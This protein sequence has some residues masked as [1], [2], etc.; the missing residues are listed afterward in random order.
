MDHYARLWPDRERAKRRPN[1][2]HRPLIYGRH[3]LDRDGAISVHQ[4]G[5]VGRQPPRAWPTDESDDHLHHT[6]EVPVVVLPLARTHGCEDDDAEPSQARWPGEA[7]AMAGTT[8]DTCMYERRPSMRSLIVVDVGSTL[9]QFT[10]DG[11]NTTAVLAGLAP[12][13]F[14]RELIARTVCRVLHRTAELTEDVIHEVCDELHID[15]ATWPDPWPA[16]SFRPYEDTLDCLARLNALAPVVALSN[17][18]VTGAPR[19]E[20]LAG[21]CGKYLTRIYPSYQLGAC[22]PARWVWRY[23]ADQHDVR[24]HHVI[25]IGDRWGEDVLGPLGV[26]GRAVW[27]NAAGMPLPDDSFVATGRCAVV[28]SLS[29]A[30][31][32][33]ERWIELPVELA[34]RPPVH[35]GWNK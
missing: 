12:A 33:V 14:P 4:L 6:L 22:K 13:T 31:T 1:R 29:T 2:A 23:A 3:T 24:P 19:M 7:L 34:P 20:A 25:H 10:G 9:G 26:G 32:T 18:S 21:E 35:R 5:Q 28:D 16:S 11:R 17:L 30:V 15:Q 27:I 8:R